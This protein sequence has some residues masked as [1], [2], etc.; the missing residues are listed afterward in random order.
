MSL[1]YA[2]PTL[3]GVGVNVYKLT[4]ENSPHPFRNRVML[5][6][7]CYEEI[8]SNVEMQVFFFSKESLRW[9]SGVGKLRSLGYLW[10]MA[11]IFKFLG[12][13]PIEE[14]WIRYRIQ[15][16][17]L[18]NKYYVITGVSPAC[19][20]DGEWLYYR[21]DFEEDNSSDSQGLT[22]HDDEPMYDATEQ[23]IEVPRE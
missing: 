7:L 17:D 1:M 10:G 13:T 5:R 14:E 16:P 18:G 3:N 22:E 19:H 11:D 12:I 6:S 20:L 8:A 23:L 15:L 9:R 21:I 2:D 4:K